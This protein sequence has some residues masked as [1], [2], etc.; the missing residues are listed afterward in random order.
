LFGSTGRPSAIREL[1]AIDD[2]IPQARALTDV[3]LVAV[4]VARTQAVVALP[5]LV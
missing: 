5:R 1:D 4:V 2:L 3:K